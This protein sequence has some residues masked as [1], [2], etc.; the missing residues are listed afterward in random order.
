MIL[1]YLD[2][3]ILYSEHPGSQSKNRNHWDI[4]SIFFHW[5]PLGICME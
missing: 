4:L 1:I 2:I 5:R 3:I